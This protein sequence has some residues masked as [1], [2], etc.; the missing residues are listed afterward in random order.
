MPRTVQDASEV[1]SGKIRILGE[2]WRYFEIFGK[3]R[4]GAARIWE[5]QSGSDSSREIRGGSGRSGEI[6]GGSERKWEVRGD[7]GRT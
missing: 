4:R 2:I 7:S 6:R 3:D 5:D 1:F